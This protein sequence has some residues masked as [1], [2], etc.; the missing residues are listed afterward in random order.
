ME[1]GLFLPRQIDQN[2][3]NSA[4][5]RQIEKDAQCLEFGQ[6]RFWKGSGLLRGGVQQLIKR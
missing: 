6:F 4:E 1:G 5:Q 3:G 2:A